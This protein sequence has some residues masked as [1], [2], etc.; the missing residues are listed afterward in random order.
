MEVFKINKRQ[1]DAN[2]LVVELNGEIDVYTA[3]DLR[4]NLSESVE[5]GPSNLII[6]LEEVHYIDSSGLSVL[7]EMHKRMR[8]KHGE[9]SIICTHSQILKLF[10]ITGLVKIL[11]LFRSEA[12]ALQATTRT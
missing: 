9:M 2:T 8:A 7:L 12:E 4:K 10:N 6:N 1:V 5:A 11:K 3:P